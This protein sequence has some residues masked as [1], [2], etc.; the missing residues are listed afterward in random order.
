MVTT[1]VSGGEFAALALGLTRTIDVLPGV[2][3][4]VLLNNFVIFQDIWIF[5]PGLTRHFGDKLL[6]KSFRLI[7]FLF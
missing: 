2:H 3:V 5:S 1:P 4:A 7:L 6:L